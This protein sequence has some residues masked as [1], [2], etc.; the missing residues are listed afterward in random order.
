MRRAALYLGLLLTACHGSGDDGD[1]GS[2]HTAT[3]TEAFDAEADGWLL[4]V[5]GPSSSDQWIAGGTPDSGKLLRYDGTNATAVTLPADTP[6]LNWSFGFGA[7]DVY[8]VGNEGTVLHW[9]GAAFTVE[10]TNTDQNLWGVWGAS[11]DDVWAVG[12]NGRAEGQLTLLRRRNGTWTSTTPPPL[13]RSNV[14]ALFKVWGTSADNVYAVGQRGTV[15]HFDGT[16]WT[17]ELVGTS[18]D[19]IALWGTGPDRIAV[20]G[21]RNN[22]QIAVWD[23][24]AWNHASLAPLPGLNGVWMR[25]PSVVHVA[26][27]TG[28]L[29]TIDF[30]SLEYTDASVIGEGRDFHAVF[31]H[32][33]GLT[34]VGGNF[35]QAQGPYR[36]IAYERPLLQ[37]E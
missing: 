33:G 14:F 21:G 25:D 32:E 23:G 37:G 9:D 5:W 22:G 36:G 11:A 2:T 7:N 16:A 4:S 3:W 29:A 1:D 35:L 12:G 19:L 10:E 34:T 15:L 30:D 18:D 8:V 28:T 31:G 17:E 6:L 13:M 20:V 24:S 26:G 27:V